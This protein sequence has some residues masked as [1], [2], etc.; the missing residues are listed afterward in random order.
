MMV[1]VGSRKVEL[2]REINMYGTAL[3]VSENIYEEILNK[4]VIPFRQ[5]QISCL[6]K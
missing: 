6:D 5:R 4:I 3:E 1:W 2:I